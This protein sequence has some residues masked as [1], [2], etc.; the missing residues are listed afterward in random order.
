MP[1]TK[2]VRIIQINSKED[3]I[4]LIGRKCYDCDDIGLES[5]YKSLLRIKDTAIFVCDKFGHRHAAKIRYS[6]PV[7]EFIGLNDEMVSFASSLAPGEREAIAL[8]R[9][10]HVDLIENLRSE[11][12]AVEVYGAD[13]D[14]AINTLSGIRDKVQQISIMFQ[15]RDAFAK[16]LQT[17]VTLNGLCNYCINVVPITVDELRAMWVSCPG[18]ASMIADVD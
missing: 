3:V 5:T 2:Q 11:H 14:G 16:F 7:E 6:M 4:G 8:K 1:K 9:M 10:G 12:G 18:C 15:R 13:V 17:N